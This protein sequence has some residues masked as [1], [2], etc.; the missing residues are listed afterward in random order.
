SVNAHEYLFPL[1]RDLNTRIESFY[2]RDSVNFHSSMKP[3]IVSELRN[4]SPLDSIQSPIA[5]D[6]K[7]NRTWTGRKLRKEHLIH[8]E[9]DDLKLSIDPVFNFQL[10]R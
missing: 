1:N 9:Q 3:F 2:E 5:K 7:F 8:I 6:C 4:N 10:G